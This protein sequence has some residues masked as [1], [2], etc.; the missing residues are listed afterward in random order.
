M[1]SDD[2]AIRETDMEVGTTR[3][4]NG[5]DRGWDNCANVFRPGWY[6]EDSDDRRR[7]GRASEKVSVPASLQKTRRTWAGAPAPTFGRSQLGAQGLVLHQALGGKAWIAA[8]EFSVQAA[9]RG[10]RH[11]VP[12]LLG[13]GPLLRL[14]GC[15][16]RKGVQR[17]LQ[18]DE[19]QA[20]ANYP[21]V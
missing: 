21:G 1:S 4:A 3:R 6:G 2:S 20:G 8:E 15:P 18:E 7:I 10:R 9:W 16:H 14:G 5:K 12:D 17:L 11:R 19:A 13:Y